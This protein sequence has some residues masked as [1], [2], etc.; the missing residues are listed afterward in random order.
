MA[1]RDVPPRAPS[2]APA[3]APVLPRGLLVLIVDDDTA[4]RDLWAA[5]LSRAPGLTTVTASNGL[6]AVRLARE[7]QPDVVLMDVTMPGMDGFVATQTLKCDRLTARI[8]VIAITACTFTPQRVR[9]AGCDGYLVKPIDPETL[10]AAIA[11][12]IHATPGGLAA[13][14][15]G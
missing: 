8:P 14:D 4:I 3:P 11:R 15:V 6:E 2:V 1:S 5:V 12:A 10:I 13:P 7:L 9:E